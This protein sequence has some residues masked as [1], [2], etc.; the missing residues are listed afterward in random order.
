MKKLFC[1]ALILLLIPSMAYCGAVTTTWRK[2]AQ[3]IFKMYKLTTGTDDPN[4]IS[5]GDTFTGPSGPLA[6]WADFVSSSSTAVYGHVRESSGTYTFELSASV[7]TIY[8]YVI[9]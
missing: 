6:Y 8:L 2:S 4:S 3:G 1:L 9:P 5:D 7:D